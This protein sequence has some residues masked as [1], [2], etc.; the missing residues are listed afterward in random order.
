MSMT[1]AAAKTYIARILGGASSTPIL[2][3]AE[4]ALYR[5]YE[6]FQLMKNWDF[7]LKDTSLGF[8][9]SGCTATASSASVSAPS[10]GAFDGVNVGM[11]VTI[12]A[13]DTA[14]LAS[15]TTVSTITYSSDGTVASITLSNAFGGTTD[16]SATLTFTGDIPII[17]STDS[18]NAPPDFYAPY[19]ARFTEDPQGPIQYVS[20]LWWDKVQRNHDANSGTAWY[21]IFNPYSELSQNYGTKRLRVFGLPDTTNI[22]RLKYYRSFVKTGTYVDMPD[23]MLY[24]FLDYG[25]TLLLE[26]K[27]AQDDPISYINRVEKKI[28]K[29]TDEGSIEENDDD[30]LKSP[31]EG[32]SRG[33][34]WGNGEFDPF[35]M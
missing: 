11:T 28:G 24:S 35:R 16:T 9:V 7:L 1:T 5:A 14:T 6:D 22:L 21:T 34:L 2:A 30:R 3:M 12:A 27:R 23:D 13:A 25:R 18:Y 31:Y 15:A 33:P 32:P 17:A 8:S 10:T 4:E 29:S 26:T 19:S 20:P